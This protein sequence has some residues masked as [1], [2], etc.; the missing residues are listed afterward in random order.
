LKTRASNS[1]RLS[2]RTEHAEGAYALRC[3]R[4]YGRHFLH[5]LKEKRELSIVVTTDDA[6]AHLNRMWRQKNRP[7]DV[8][9]FGIDGSPE[10]LG[11]VVIS[12]DTA[13]RQA[14]EGRR[15]LID[16]LARLLAHGVLHLMGHDHEVPA[17]ARRMAQAEVD[18]LGSVG[19]VG[20]ALDHP[21]QLSFKRARASKKNSR[22]PSRQRTRRPLGHAAE[23]QS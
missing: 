21:A 2:A 12:L 6:I 20:E 18:L 16:E 19:L 9:S 22:P 17:D 5:E 11:D 7:T 10:L 3:L 14:A 13:R 4:T 8:L 23:T 1:L 15:T